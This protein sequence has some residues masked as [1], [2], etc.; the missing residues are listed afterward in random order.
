MK[1]III[2]DFKSL[3]NKTLKEVACKDKEGKFKYFST[4]EYPIRHKVTN[5]QR[6]SATKE[7]EYRKNKELKENDLIF[8][9]MW[10]SFEPKNEFYIW[11]HRVRAY[12]KNK[13]NHLCFVEVWTNNRKQKDRPENQTMCG[14]FSYNYKLNPENYN[15]WNLLN[16]INNDIIGYTKPQLLEIVNN[17]FDCNYKEIYFSDLLYCDELKEKLTNN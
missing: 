17:Y 4:T 9:N 12:F 13:S 7:I 11:N 8:I 16:D 15:H 6:E 14:D 2:K 1:T 10:M 5:E 3:D